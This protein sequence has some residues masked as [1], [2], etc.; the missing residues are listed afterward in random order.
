MKSANLQGILF[1]VILGICTSV[2]KVSDMTERAFDAISD[3]EW[4]EPSGEIVARGIDF[5]TF[6]REYWDGSARYEYVRGYVIKMP[7]PTLI[8]HDTI[9]FL[10][11]LFIFY[12]NMRP[13]GRVFREMV[14]FRR[15]DLHI[16]RQ[17]DLMIVLND[18]QESL[19]DTGVEGAPDIVIEVVSK[20]SRHTD[21]SDKLNEY[22]MAGV[23]E[24]WLFDQKL[25]KPIFNRLDEDGKFYQH[26]LGREL[27]YRTPL[28][29]NFVLDVSLLWQNPLPSALE[30]VEMVKDM[31]KDEN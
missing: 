19:T 11:L 5:D 25:Q 15:R 14:E 31:L 7:A 3:L 17:P 24:Y 28:L 1:G 20:G 8:H 10:Q 21:Y 26:T 6:E 30:V 16:R 2:A 4:D 12:F 23:K 29:P 22:E 27:L 9:T 13:I 18:N